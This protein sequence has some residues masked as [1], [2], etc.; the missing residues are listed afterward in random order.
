MVSQYK[1]ENLVILEILYNSMKLLRAVT[2]S[3]HSRPDAPRAV[4]YTHLTLPTSD[5]V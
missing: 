5:L 2:G 4:S 3:G 1:L